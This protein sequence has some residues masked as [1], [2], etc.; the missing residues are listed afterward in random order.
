MSL[1]RRLAA[2]EA[3]LPPRNGGN[4]ARERLEAK[5]MAVAESHRLGRQRGEEPVLEGQSMASLL[6]LI[7]SHGYGAVPHE[8][9]RAAWDKVQEMN[10][11]LRPVVS[12]LVR[13]S[14]VSKG[15]R[16]IGGGGLG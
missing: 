16:S 15:Y 13:R 6:A 3:S 10:P 7:H 11:G 14:L 12:K 1:E 8:V 9:A 4:G 5:L 2:L